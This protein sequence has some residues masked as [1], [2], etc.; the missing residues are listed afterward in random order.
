MSSVSLLQRLRGPFNFLDP[1]PE[2]VRTQFPDA[3]QILPAPAS[4][5]L[6]D[7]AATPLQGFPITRSPAIV[8]LR[9]S[10]RAWVESEERAKVL[11]LRGQSVDIPA[12]QALWESYRSGLLA[13]AE[14]VMATSHGRRYAQ[15]FW[16]LHS[17]DLAEALRGSVTRI[18]QLDLEIGKE[19][20]DLIRYA[21]LSKYLDATL[22][23]IYDLAARL[24]QQTL[25]GELDV[26]PPLLN[27]LCDNVL[28]FTE[29]HVSRDLNEL[30]SYFK[31]YL[32][33]DGSDFLYRL[34]LLRRWHSETL[35]DD[36]Q[37]RAAARHLLGQQADAP[38]DQL[39]FGRGYL[40]YLS[41][42]PDYD[43]ERLLGPREI[44]LW[45]SLLIKLKEFELFSAVRRMIVELEERDGNLWCGS[46]SASRLGAGSRPLR[47][48]PET[49]PLDFSVSWIVDPEVTR[50]GLI[51]DLVDFS[52]QVSRLRMSD[53]AAQDEAFRRIFLFQL[54]INRLTESL[55]LRMEKYLGDGAFFSS[56]HPGRLLI[57]AL[58][59]QQAYRAAVGSGFVFDRGLRLGLNSG[60]YRLLP[61][62]RSIDERYEVFGHG[63]V[64]LNRLVTGKRTLDI[65]DL[66]RSLVIK[67]YSSTLVHEFFAPLAHAS[68][69]ATIPAD[70]PF[71]AQLEPDGSLV[72]Q[73]IVATRELLRDLSR[74]MTSVPLHLAKDGALRFVVFRLAA[75][76]GRLY[77][78]G[79]RRLG[80]A[81]LKGLDAVDVYEVVDGEP[82]AYEELEPIIG[83]GLI[84]ALQESFS[85]ALVGAARP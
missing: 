14:N 57:A 70:R 20:G 29:D 56:R 38:P 41:E 7:E 4:I 48:S 42:H 32:K 49:R 11:G 43:G 54:Q 44:K 58:Q 74:S 67:G 82:W 79:I 39:L 71:Y 55:G 21:V 78:F 40:A 35:A 64:E 46:R 84:D 19:R 65:D 22:Y 18:R 62:S 68:S 53:R 9:E 8:R 23:A 28:I 26:F 85:S 3:E 59:I 31:G 17:G 75:A 50:G 34:A 52:A 80:L 2:A 5:F 10:L 51:Y 27:R 60:S 66:K 45:E 33:I 73:G 24:S 47:L 69:E 1:R 63:L 72:N 36:P 6:I 25:R 15:V 13:L 76:D 77:T 12:H 16:L 37:L 81:A 30:K 61:L 83:K